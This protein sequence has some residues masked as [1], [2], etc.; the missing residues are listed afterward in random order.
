MRD[1]LTQDESED[2]QLVRLIRRKLMEALLAGNDRPTDE[3]LEVFTRLLK[4]FES[5]AINM[6]K[7]RMSR[8]TN[9][10]Q[11]EHSAVLLE[12]VKSLSLPQEELEVIHIASE[13]PELPDEYTVKDLPAGI[14]SQ[15][16]DL[17]PE[18]LDL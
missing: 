5:G 1:L 4:D 11:D 7:L 16:K 14:T 10:T 9:D 6:A 8:E 15:A 17:T 12:L 18:D 2:Y 3:N 13:P